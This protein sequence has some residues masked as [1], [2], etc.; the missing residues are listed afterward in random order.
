MSLTVSL[1]GKENVEDMVTDALEKQ[2]PSPHNDLFGVE[3]C[4]KTLSGNDLIVE[5]GCEL[6]PILKTHDIIVYDEYIEKLRREFLIL[7]DNLD[8]ISLHT[9][10]R[11]D[12][13]EFRVNNALEIIKIALNNLDK[14]GVWIG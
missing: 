13:I 6:I 4:R 9:N 12:Y 3:S 8:H 14:V 2:V 7:L 1:T 10:Y 11:K 5:L